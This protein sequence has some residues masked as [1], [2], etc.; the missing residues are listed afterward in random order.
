[1][2]LYNLDQSEPPAKK[3]AVEILRMDCCI[4]RIGKMYCEED[5]KEESEKLRDVMFEKNGKD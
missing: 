5:R 3:E 2:I 4:I 1:M